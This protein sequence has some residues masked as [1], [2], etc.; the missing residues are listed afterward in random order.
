MKL[1]HGIS[2]I[3]P[4]QV[5]P[6]TATTATSS[7]MAACRRYSPSRA[8]QWTSARSSAA[9]RSDRT[10]AFP[11]SRAGPHVTIPAGHDATWLIPAHRMTGSLVSA[12]RSQPNRSTV[13]A[14]TPDP[15]RAP[16][17]AG[18]LR[19]H[20]PKVGAQCG[21]SARWDLC[22]GPPRGRSLLRLCMTLRRRTVTDMRGVSRS[23]PELG[24]STAGWVC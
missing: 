6:T 14:D 13:P 12:A 8:S 10:W 17:P 5:A 21:N 4:R 19:R 22:G 16:L 9:A 3:C 23:S 15:H 18:T 7:P 24:Y 1:I 20:A 11:R 2:A